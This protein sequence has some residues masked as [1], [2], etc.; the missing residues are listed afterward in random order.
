MSILD[1]TPPR[2]WD[3]RPPFAAHDA[4]PV[5]ELSGSRVCIQ[6]AQAASTCLAMCR[7]EDAERADN[8]LRNATSCPTS[9]I[10]LY[11]PASRYLVEVCIDYLCLLV[12][13]RSA[14]VYPGSLWITRTRSRQV[15]V[16]SRL[17]TQQPVHSRHGATYCR[18]FIC[19]DRACMHNF[20]DF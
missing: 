9:A 11:V 18:R 13:L 1:K 6:L 12:T 20:F 14:G 19:F 7:Q 3:P 4:G 8:M 10:H 2:Y 15:A 16:E 5:I 17:A